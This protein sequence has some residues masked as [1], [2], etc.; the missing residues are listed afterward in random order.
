I[1]ERRAK[2]AG[3]AHVEMDQF[4]LEVEAELTPQAV[5]V[6]PGNILVPVSNIHSLYHLGNVL[7]RVK[8]GRRDVVVLHVRLL[9]RSASGAYELEAEQPVGGI[10]QRLF[11]QSQA[12]AETRG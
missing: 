1:S 7:D 3:A 4:N 10:E 9:R 12:M 2:R 11:S 8:P 6:R 5:G